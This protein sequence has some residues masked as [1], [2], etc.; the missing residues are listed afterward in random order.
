MAI[1]KRAKRSGEADAADG[2]AAILEGYELP[3]FPRVVT[4]AIEKVSG[5]DAD[6][7]DVADTLKDDPGLSVHLLRLVNSASFAPRRPIV[8]LHQAVMMLGRNQ[9]ESILI[10]LAVNESLPKGP[11]PG[12]DS[13]DFWTTA[14]KRATVAAAYA[15]VLDP[16]RRS[17]NFTAAL[18]ADLALP[19]LAHQIEGYGDLLLQAAATR[20]PLLE[21]EH[22]EFA[23]D[24][25]KVGGLM[26]VT[27][28]FPDQLAE[29]I[30]NHHDPV[31]A[32]DILPLVKVAAAVRDF[33]DEEC[34]QNF[35]ADITQTFGLPTDQAESILEGAFA[36]ASAT[37]AMFA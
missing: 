21:I 7:N 4:T 2:L 36:D 30:A 13:Q 27:W 25:Q 28:E 37:A 9:L 11:I 22:R 19:V 34:R 29:A 31:E 32:S 35:L 14:A 20:D 6:L 26:C 33:D 5:A 24:H 23:W 1:L 3:S 17:E 15:N 10:C 16:S 8:D 12:F 18:L